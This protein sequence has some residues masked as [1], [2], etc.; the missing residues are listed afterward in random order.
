MNTNW[1][2][3]ISASLNYHMDSGKSGV[4]LFIEGEKRI[5]GTTAD[6]FELR[7]NGPFFNEVS[8]GVWRVELTVNLLVSCTMNKTDLYNLQ[9]KIGIS[10]GMMTSIPL[11][12]Y[13]TL[14][15][16]DDQTLFACM[17]LIEGP[18]VT[19]Y[20][21]VDPSVEVVQATVQGRYKTLL[22]D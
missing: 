10:L 11:Y 9:R 13:G 18:T 3:W 2:R 17:Q 21:Q 16:I 12:K 14:T 1:P 8:A 22:E 15:G 6:R 4:K 20:G 5:T 7:T 19:Q